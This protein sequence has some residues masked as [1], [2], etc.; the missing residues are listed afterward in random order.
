MLD[1]LRDLG[2]NYLEVMLFLRQIDAG[3]AGDLIPRARW[4]C[5]QTRI[6]RTLRVESV[7][8]DG[9]CI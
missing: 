1:H 5:V 8:P 7:P 2:V 4:E 9:P 6:V 3:L